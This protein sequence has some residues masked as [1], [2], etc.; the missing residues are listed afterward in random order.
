VSNISH[1][2]FCQAREAKRG[3]ISSI[4]TAAAQ[5][6]LLPFEN[7]PSHEGLVSVASVEPGASTVTVSWGVEVTAAALIPNLFDGKFQ[8]LM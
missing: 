1:H 6:G 7:S 8:K 3:K 5:L 2:F 4:S